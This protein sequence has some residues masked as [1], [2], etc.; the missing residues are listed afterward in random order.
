M[1]EKYKIDAAFFDDW[2]ANYAEIPIAIAD[3]DITA[4][5]RIWGTSKEI[6]MSKNPGNVRDWIWAGALRQ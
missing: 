5:N 4:I 2:F 3:E 6:G 1:A